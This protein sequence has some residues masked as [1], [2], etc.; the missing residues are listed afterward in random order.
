MTI[1]SIVD[2][3]GNSFN[4]CLI[5]DNSFKMILLDTTSAS[6]KGLLSDLYSTL[7]LWL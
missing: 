4:I 3:C 7:K 6:V 2:K 1:K 5:D